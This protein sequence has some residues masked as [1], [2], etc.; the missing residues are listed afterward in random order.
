M[1]VEEFDDLYTKIESKYPEHEAKRLHRKDRIKAIGQGRK[2]K[3]ELRDRLLML[4]VYY[5]LY[6]TYCLT[7]FLFNLD[8]SNVHRNIKYLVPLVKACIPLPEKL[9]KKIRRIGIW[10][11]F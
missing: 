9:H 7:G 1:K 5:K 10:R 11:N 2:F 4:L 8:Q 6:I 3:L